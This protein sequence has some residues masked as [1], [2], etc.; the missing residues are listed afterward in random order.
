MQSEEGGGQQSAM[1][2][3]GRPFALPAGG[4]DATLRC[5]VSHPAK[6]IIHFFFAISRI[7]PIRRTGYPEFSSLRIVL[8][9]GLTIMPP[10]FQKRWCQIHH[11][12]F[13]VSL[14]RSSEG[15]KTRRTTWT[16]V[17]SSKDLIHCLV[18]GGS[19]THLIP[20]TTLARACSNGVPALHV[21]TP[22]AQLHLSVG[23]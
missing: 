12:G 10:S 9:W 1:N 21:A 11:L 8:A 17:T 6:T 20:V 5:N 18:P 2:L 19:E 3:G 13:V 23:S 14:L 4:R 7:P 22:H 15:D 16:L